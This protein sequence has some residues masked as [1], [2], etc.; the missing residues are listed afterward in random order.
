MNYTLLFWGSI[1]L[2]LY[3]LWKFATR[4]TLHLDRHEYLEVMSLI[5]WQE[6]R[7]IRLELQRIHGGYLN[8][9]TFYLNLGKLEEEGFIERQVKTKTLR[10]ITCTR[11]KFRKK[12]KGRPRRNS[13]GTLVPALEI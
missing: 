6:G 9:G 1:A 7:T 11:T 12:P 5:E 13:L 4:N 8:Y 3:V 10:S 2:L